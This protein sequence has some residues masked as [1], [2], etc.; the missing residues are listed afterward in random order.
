MDAPRPVHLPA[1][2]L[3]PAALGF[4][5][6]AATLAASPERPWP[7]GCVGIL[8]LGA[9]LDRRLRTCLL[10]ALL[11]LLAGSADA[12]RER[13]GLPL[14]LPGVYRIRGTVD[15]A[16]LPA[17][18]AGRVHLEPAWIH[19]P[20]GWRRLP[21]L[22]LRWRQ[23][24]CALS[25]PAPGARVESEMRLSR[26]SRGTGAALRAWVP[27]CRSMRVGAP[28]G[29]RAG[30]HRARTRSAERLQAR[31]SARDAGLARALLLGDRQRLLPQDRARF[32]ETGQ[33]HLLAVSGLHVGLVVA[34]WMLLLLWLRVPRRPRLVLGIVATVAFVAMAGAPPSAL[35]AGAGAVF[36]MAACLAGRRTPPLRM[37]LLVG[38]A[39]VWGDTRSVRAPAFQMSFGAV[40][41]ILVFAPLV[42][43][44]FVSPRPV[45]PGH[46]PPVRAPLRSLLA[47]GLAAW[48]GAAPF[49]AMHIGQLA[50]A[51]PLVALPAVPLTATLIASGLLLLLDPPRPGLASGAA[52][53]FRLTADALR[54]WLDTTRL[55]GATTVPVRP[56]PWFWWP[57]HA[58]ALWLATREA[59]RTRRMGLGLLCAL[60]LALAVGPSG[61]RQY[62]APPSMPSP[63]PLLTTAPDPGSWFPLVVGL[64]MPALL[65]FAVVSV[66]PLR[67]LRRGGAVGAAVLGSAAGLAFH[68]AGLAG[69]FAPF[70]VATLL[71]RLPGGERAGPR[72]WRQVFSNGLPAF[73]GCVL[74][75]LGLGGWLPALW[76]PG[77]WVFLGALACLGADTSATEV[78]TRLGRRV[79]RLAG[80]GPIQRG[81]SGGVSV[82]GL[83]AAFAGSH[84]AP[85]AF[86]LCFPLFGRTL[87]LMH[88]P[89]FIAPLAGAGFA[90][91]VIDSVLGGTLQFRGRDPTNGSRTEQTTC[92]GT[93]SEHVSGWRWLD[94]D[95]VNLVSGLAASLVALAL[96]GLI[97]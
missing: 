71:G 91:A 80:R 77:V 53:L 11:G 10:G 47:V 14:H 27:D 38:C 66:H 17:F 4:L 8:L 54:W 5:G 21:A 85:L 88:Y 92:A 36:W 69:L 44:L 46:L 48:L 95:R 6:G 7:L 41:G 76:T 64:V 93:P 28:R 87:T 73:C 68:L 15:S 12:R 67:W 96:F 3:L 19:T 83:L 37:L 26:P 29:P 78:G 74:G 82:P 31:L 34:G 18:G 24:G 65:V 94:N 61:P 90:G 22:D 40:A 56:P 50:P 51:G 60:V 86:A 81:E 63:L 97:H 42:R 33:S 84:L 58:G 20:D 13:L 45:I 59:L 9:C 52:G 55:L 16:Y 32:R 43:D 2:L 49:V 57:A 79:F 30:L 35:R 75:L 23:T 25:P 70:V 89:C 39:V 72:S 1:E 62:D